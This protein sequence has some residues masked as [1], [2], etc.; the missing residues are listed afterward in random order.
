MISGHFNTPRAFKGLECFGDIWEFLK[1]LV[2]FIMLVIELIVVNF[3]LSRIKE[4]FASHNFREW[5]LF[6]S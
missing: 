3:Q 1:S 4:Y 2:S 5:F 6:E